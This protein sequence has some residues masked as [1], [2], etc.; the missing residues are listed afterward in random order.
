M[1]EWADD[2]GYD[3]SF[4]EG[5]HSLN[6]VASHSHEQN[7]SEKVACM[8]VLLYNHTVRFSRESISYDN[9]RTLPLSS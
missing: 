6:V 2:S 3:G 5:K 9:A 7:L 4:P 8:E 1:C